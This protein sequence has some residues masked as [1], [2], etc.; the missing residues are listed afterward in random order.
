MNDSSKPY[1]LGIVLGGLYKGEDVSPRT[2]VIR[3]M[4]TV[5][6]AIT[7]RDAAVVPLVVQG[8]KTVK[9][10]STLSASI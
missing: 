7:P 10:V 3:A 1:L 6:D 4:R 9:E 8:I 2:D 5:L